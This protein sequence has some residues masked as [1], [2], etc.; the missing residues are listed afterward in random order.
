MSGAGRTGNHVPPDPVNVSGL[1]GGGL[2]GVVTR[3]GGGDAV[4]DAVG[5]PDDAGGFGVRLGEGVVFSGLGPGARGDG[6][7]LY[8]VPGG[9][10]SGL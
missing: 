7:G 6:T 2:A 1:L 5:G 9:A 4:G 10:G 8:V 3:L